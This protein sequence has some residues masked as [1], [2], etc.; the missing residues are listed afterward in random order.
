M[1]LISRMKGKDFP[2]GRN[3]NT[4]FKS[5]ESNK[6]A[7]RGW[8]RAT[9]PLF[10]RPSR[11]DGGHSTTKGLDSVAT[12]IDHPPRLSRMI[13]WKRPQMEDPGSNRTS[14]SGPS[15]YVRSIEAQ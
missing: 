3:E 9:S 6:K 10:R 15:F 14:Q 11:C 12:G 7:V 2:T 1:E 8:L 13:N 5:Y 4:L